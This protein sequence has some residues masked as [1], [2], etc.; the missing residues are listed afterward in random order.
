MYE[1]KL[2]SVGPGVVFSRRLEPWPGDY[3]AH[4]GVGDPDE[5]GS[6]HLVPECP[7][8]G[9]IRVVQIHLRPGNMLQ[10]FMADVQALMFFPG[11]DDRLDLLL[12]DPE[13][14]LGSLEVGVLL[15]DFPCLGLTQVDLLH[16]VVSGEAG[17]DPRRG[18]K[19]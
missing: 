9:A 18:R 8:V 1:F 12:G 17:C 16:V 11:F 19:P 7:G 3:P 10:S 14:G 5:A 13:G 2:G 15:D 4:N 6:L